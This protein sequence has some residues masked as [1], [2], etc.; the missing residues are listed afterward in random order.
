MTDAMTE[1]QLLAE[2][3]LALAKAVRDA[4]PPVINV[5]VQA[6]EGPEHPISVTVIERERDDTPPSVNVPVTVQPAKVEIHEAPETPEPE[7][8]RE[9]EIVYATEGMPRIIGIRAKE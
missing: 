2:A 9:W 4:P 7:P 5:T 1:I 3:V 6:P 8:P